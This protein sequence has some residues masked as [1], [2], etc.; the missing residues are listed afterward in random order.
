MENTYGEYEQWPSNARVELVKLMSNSEV[1]SEEEAN[2]WRTAHESERQEVADEVLAMHFEGMTYIDTYNAM[3]RE[4]GPIE[5][6]SDE[7]RALYTSILQQYGKYG[8]DWPIYV[9]PS[10]TDITRNEAIGIAKKSVLAMFS[11]E[12][13][14]LNAM[15]VDAIFSIDPYNTMGAPS[16]EPFREINFGYGLAYRIYMTR[17]GKMLGVSGPKTEFY[18]WNCEIDAG[19]K[20]AEVSADCVSTD[21]AIAEARS[22]LGE[23]MNV[24][25]TDL[26]FMEATAKLIYCDLYCNGEEPV[27]LIT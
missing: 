17:T 19:A 18:P 10:D 4:L 22:A 12:E 14:Q 16:D 3:A 13:D 7:N 24:P 6:W 25:Y 2:L 11:L 15:S 8:M 1:L 23:I 9:V 21:I 27:W 20:A 5:M 26:D